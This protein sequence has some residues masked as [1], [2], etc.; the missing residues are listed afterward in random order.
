MNNTIRFEVYAGMDEHVYKHI[1][2]YAMSLEHIKSNGN[3]IT[4]SEKHR[5]YVGF[6]Q[7]NE[8]A[9]FCSIKPQEQPARNM[10]MGNLF[11]FSS[12]VKK[13]FDRL[14]KQI[15]RDITGR[16]ISLTSYANNDNMKWFKKLGFETIK[17]GV[18]WHN[19]KY[20]DSLRSDKKKA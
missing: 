19:M 12:D 10:Q 17:E 18:N 7:E 2:P 5:W 3:P 8:V 16:G 11:I 1:G 4:T 9:C 13:A 20:N 15:I 14:V 6:N